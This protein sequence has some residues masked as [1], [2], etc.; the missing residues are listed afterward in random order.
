MT[1]DRSGSTG[2]DHLFVRWGRERAGDCEGKAG[3]T[4]GARTRGT[5]NRCAERYQQGRG[6]RRRG[7]G[8]GA[9]GGGGCAPPPTTGNGGPQRRGGGGRAPAGEGSGSNRP[10]K[11]P[12][13]GRVRGGATKA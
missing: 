9:G 13:G 2:N 11:E 4:T 3:Q 6:T 7:G 12:P 5:S 1:R 8:T 10:E